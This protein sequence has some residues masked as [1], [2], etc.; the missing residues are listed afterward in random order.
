[1]RCEGLNYAKYFF[2]KLQMRFFGGLG[3]KKK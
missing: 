3:L 2:E 1:M